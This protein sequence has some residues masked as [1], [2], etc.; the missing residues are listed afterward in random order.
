MAFSQW[1]LYGCN[2]A[3]R[4]MDIE[5]LKGIVKNHNLDPKYKFNDDDVKTIMGF[6]WPTFDS[7]KREILINNMCGATMIS[8][9]HANLWIIVVT[10]SF[11]NYVTIE[12]A[13]D[14]VIQV[15]N[16]L[17]RS[18]YVVKDAAFRELNNKKYC[19][20]NLMFQNADHCLESYKA[21]SAFYSA[22]DSPMK[23]T[24]VECESWYFPQG[25][26]AEWRG[27]MVWPVSG[28]VLSA[29]YMMKKHKDPNI[30]FHDV[31]SA[32]SKFQDARGTYKV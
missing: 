9:F 5:V 32:S 12:K 21:L 22:G 29:S 18:N 3:S 26:V 31:Y 6:D 27:M 1:T 16:M 15:I 30:T 19:Y 25:E 17:T 14:S 24:A 11:P 10:I 23:I 8:N 13:S 7:L 4:I 20:V 2:K 28:Q